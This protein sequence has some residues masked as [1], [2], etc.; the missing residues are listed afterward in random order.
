MYWMYILSYIVLSQKWLNKDNQTNI[1][2]QINLMKL[3][4]TL[5]REQWYSSGSLIAVVKI[6]INRLVMEFVIC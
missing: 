1:K 5:L 3:I 2:T 4:Y 6:T